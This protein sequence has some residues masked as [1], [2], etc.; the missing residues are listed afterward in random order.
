MKYVIYKI[1]GNGNKEKLIPS[2]RGQAKEE[3]QS[4]SLLIVCCVVGAAFPCSHHFCSSTW[5]QVNPQ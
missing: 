4:Q 1:I 3:K 2:K 5:S